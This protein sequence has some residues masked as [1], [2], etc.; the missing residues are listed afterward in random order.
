MGS[1]SN[2]RN[3]H[4]ESLRLIAMLGITLNHFP[5]D[6]FALSTNGATGF[7]TQFIVNLLSNFG[8]IGDCLFFG[9]SAW[10]ISGEAQGG[11]HKNL[12]RIFKIELQL[13]FYSISLFIVSFAIP[14]VLAGTCSFGSISH[15]LF[16]AVFPIASTHWWYPTSYV[17]FLLFCPFLNKGLRAL[18]RREH[19]LLAFILLVLYG[20]FPYSFLDGLVHFDMSYSVWLFLYQYV[21]FTYIKWYC[22]EAFRNRSLGWRL[23]GFGLVS[24][25]GLQIAF[26]MPLLAAGKSMLSHQLWFNTPACLPPMLVAIG[27]LILALAKTPIANPVL[28]RA[29][30]GTLAVYLIVTDAATS[31]LIGKTVAFMGLSGFQYLAL[32]LIVSAAIF[33]ISI[34]IDLIRQLLCQRLDMFLLRFLNRLLMVAEH[35]VL[36]I[37]RKCSLFD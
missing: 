20:L 4:V 5:W 23:V 32:A 19:T 24:G 7:A 14:H 29:A 3:S 6:Y 35:A 9:I 18:N 25:I 22:P 34:S 10:F 30:S 16:E 11:L 8:G 36:D 17:L 21:I 26:G 13:L 2:N 1:I 31:E 33:V 12:K 28:N 15:A 37:Y 27:L